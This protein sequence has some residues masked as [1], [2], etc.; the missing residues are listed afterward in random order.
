M[1]AESNGNLEDD[2]EVSDLVWNVAA[3][4][5]ACVEGDIDWRQNELV[6]DDADPILMGWADGLFQIRFSYVLL[7]AA[8]L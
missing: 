8:S 2:E 3:E 6:G 1:D 7:V 4:W 5:I